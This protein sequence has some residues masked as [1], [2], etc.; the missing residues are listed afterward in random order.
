MAVLPLMPVTDQLTSDLDLLRTTREAPTV[1]RPSVL[2]RVLVPVV[3]V[4]ALGAAGYFAYAKFAAEV[5]KQDVKT[6]EVALISPS[7]AEVLVTATGY[8]IP[9]VTSKVGAKAPGRVSK[10]F[11]QEGDLV[12]EGDVI[13]QLEDT[14]QRSAMATAGSRVSVAESRIATAGANLAEITVQ[15]DRERQLVSSGAVGKA[16]LDNLVARQTALREAV[17]TAEAEAHSAK[18]EAGAVGVTLRGQTVTAPISGKIVDKPATLGEFIGGVGTNS[19]V[20]EIVDF[21]S[22]MV[23][24]DVP[25]GRLHMIKPGG[26]CE[27]VLDAYPQKRYR[28]EVFVTGL[29][30]NRAKG[31]VMVK[32]KLTDNSEGALPEMTARV[33]FLSKAI[34]DDALKVAPKKVVPK[35]AVVERN[36]QQVVFTVDGGKLH[37]FNVK[38]AGPVG[39]SA[40]ELTDGPPEKT[41]IVA[42]PTNETQDG[43]RIKDEK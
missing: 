11:V 24:T 40:V 19:L 16:N 25:E 31:T 30:V 9:Q 38:V 3:V 43:Q 23:E 26:P 18:A 39:D 42:K 34:T 7:Q 8:V 6:S 1:A 36:G 35:D 41:K 22:L 33:N 27:I 12:K 17:K 32:V 20:A 2:R 4:G 15:V 5:F 28:G 37:L 14:D 29:K 13:V 21:N 10:V